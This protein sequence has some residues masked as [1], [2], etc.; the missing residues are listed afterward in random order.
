[1]R[2]QY[3]IGIEQEFQIV[4][5]QTG[6][7]CPRAPELVA[8][9]RHRFGRQIKTEVHHAMI[10]IVTG[11]CGGLTEVDATVRQQRQ[12]LFALL[13]DHGFSAIAAATHPRS[14]WQ[15]QSISR[16]PHYE[17]LEERF[18]DTIRTAIVFGLHIHVGLPSTSD[19]IKLIN[20]ACFMLPHLLALSASSP[21]WGGRNTGFK[22]YRTA[23]IGGLPRTGLPHQFESLPIYKAEI[24]RMGQLNA[25][26]ETSRPLW[27]L[28]F[29]QTYGTVEFR[30]TDMPTHAR[31]LLALTAFVLQLVAA[32]DRRHGRHTMP[33][34]PRWAVEENKWRAARYGLDG[35]MIKLD[36]SGEQA[37]RNSVEDLLNIADMTA[38]MVIKP[39]YLTLIE[40]L[41][42]EGTS[43][44]R[45]LAVWE[46]SGGA[47][48]P[49]VNW[50]IQETQ[51]E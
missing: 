44:D 14:H 23:I 47:L 42:D 2:S 28:R 49:V 17:Q 37:T 26:D 16:G 5:A 24:R 38:P 46:Q 22:S 34:I 9:G 20:Q 50:L 51:E 40:E 43:A 35:L 31:D 32:M 1:M 41:I 21:F 7:L 45:Q 19:P 3:T 11:V 4:D 25:V 27:D 33:T 48:Q 18:Q 29:H 13:R 6:D 10:E 12:D 39:E 30:I 8:A 15:D 36:G